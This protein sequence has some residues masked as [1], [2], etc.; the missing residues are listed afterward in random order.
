LQAAA[1]T[2]WHGES[3]NF[4]AAQA[5]YRHRAR[6]TGAARRGEYSQEIERELVGSS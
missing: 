4:A 5:Q 1:L 6:C 3:E 2:T